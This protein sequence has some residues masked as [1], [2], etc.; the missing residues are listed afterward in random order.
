MNTGRL[1]TGAWRWFGGALAAATMLSP[2][3]HAGLGGPSHVQAELLA[4]PSAIHPGQ[5][6]W[7][8]VRLQMQSGWHTYWRNPGDA[9]LATTVRWELPEGFEA[10]PIQWP[11][12]MRL[13]DP[14]VTSYGYEGDVWLL[15]EIRPP[16][17]FASPDDV[18]L[19]G[20]A[21][22]VECKETGIKGQ[23]EL[24]L[25]LPVSTGQPIPDAARSAE[26]SKARAQLPV[27]LPD[28]RFRAAADKKRF[29]LHI[30]PPADL[31]VPSDDLTFF[32][33]ESG[34]IDHAAEQRVSRT[35]DGV[36]IELARSTFSSAPPAR[37]TGVLV[38]SKG[39]FGDGSPTAIRI[40]V[41]VEPAA[42]P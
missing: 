37:L 28:W 36:S 7:I 34:V 27:V 20:R 11:A 32:P 9:G 5:P 18:T 2:H 16:A 25:T 15:Q 13:G 30:V 39:W 14:T 6:F 1:A 23:K 21:E 41:P 26:F 17:I 22:W 12:P 19:K 31:S 4:E 38:S 35:S 10:G 24:Q 29:T 40:D 3:A 33:E 8:A 42:H